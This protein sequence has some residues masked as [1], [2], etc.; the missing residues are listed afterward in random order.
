M[1]IA[2]PIQ[3]ERTGTE[4]LLRDGLY[5]YAAV[6]SDPVTQGLAAS[7]KASIDK[8]RKKR[9]ETEEKSD[10]LLVSQALLDRTDYELD[11][12]LRRSELEALAETDKSR[13]DSRYQALLPDGLTALVVKWGA[14]EARLVR[15]YRKALEEHFPSVAK[16]Y[17][18]ELD[19]KAD[20][21]EAAETKW[22]QAQTDAGQAQSAVF[23]AKAELVRTLRK[24]EA[25]LL[26]LFPGQRARV[27]SYFR[28]KRGRAVADA[29]TP[30]VTP[31]AP[32]P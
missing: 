18:K 5:H 30:A 28:K 14:E 13:E 6:L 26:G 25:A 8:L 2:M 16:R 17:S 19:L 27:R 3:S 9:A 12:L 23:L 31:S 29:P 11:T 22:A 4:E 7:I 15:K 20:A 1:R 10:A 32:Q 24:S 21:T